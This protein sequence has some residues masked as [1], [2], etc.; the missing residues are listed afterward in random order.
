M[1]TIMII[2]GIR[3]F[4][5]SKEVSRP[6]VHIEYAEFEMAVWLDNLNIK[7][8]CSSKIVERKLLK[9]TKLHLEELREGWKKFYEEKNR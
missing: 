2:R 8:N 9:L 4:I 3:F 1:P 6:H 5:Y 7:K